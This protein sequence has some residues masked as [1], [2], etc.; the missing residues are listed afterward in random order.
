MLCRLLLVALRFTSQ[1]GASSP[2]YLPLV[3]WAPVWSLSSTSSH[4]GWARPRTSRAPVAFHSWPR[5]HCWIRFPLFLSEEQLSVYGSVI[6]TP[7]P[8]FNTDPRRRGF[9]PA[10]WAG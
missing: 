1:D 8:A 4:H 3:S 5:F 7:N 2:Q 9:A 10:G 6:G